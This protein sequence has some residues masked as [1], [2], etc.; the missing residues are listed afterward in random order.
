MKSAFSENMEASVGREGHI[1][2]NCK[3]SLLFKICIKLMQYSLILV[4][5][6]VSTVTLMD[7]QRLTPIYRR[8]VSESIL[9][10]LS[11]TEPITPYKSPELGSD[12][13]D[14]QVLCNHSFFGR[15]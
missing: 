9:Y 7:E 4:A 5:R 3:Y 15:Y 13:Y 6:S 11:S 1:D 14:I 8:N 2:T 12:A 10:N